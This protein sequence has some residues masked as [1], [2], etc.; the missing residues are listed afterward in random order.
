MSSG[1]TDLLQTLNV[2]FFI[3]VSLNRKANGRCERFYDRELPLST[4]CLRL[5][6]SAASEAFNTELSLI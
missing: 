1:I 6:F 5:T 4:C 2:L 3:D